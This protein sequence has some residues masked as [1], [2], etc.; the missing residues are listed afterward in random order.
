MI[1]K[2]AQVNVV[3]G[4]KKNVD[5]NVEIRIHV[6]MKGQMNILVG[7]TTI[8]QRNTIAAVTSTVMRLGELS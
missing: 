6:T 2:S 8:V 5:K 3:K 4:I 7:M 1:Q